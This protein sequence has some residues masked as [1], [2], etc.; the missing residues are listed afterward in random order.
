MYPRYGIQAFYQVEVLRGFGDVH[1]NFTR[2]G[3]TK[4]SFSG[5]R[6]A[7]TLL[8]HSHSVQLLKDIIIYNRELTLSLITA[9]YMSN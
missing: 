2:R 6:L 3:P 8:L 5:Y 4:G 7:Q 1:P 9:V